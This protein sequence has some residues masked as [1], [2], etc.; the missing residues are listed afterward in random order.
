MVSLSCGNSSFHPALALA[1]DPS[2][3]SISSLTYPNMRPRHALTQMP[4]KYN[5]TFCFFLTCDFVHKKF[6][7][8]PFLAG[9]HFQSPALPT[10]SP[11]F[12]LDHK[13]KI[14]QPLVIRTP[15]H[16]SLLRFSPSFLFCC[17]VVFM[18]LCPCKFSFYFL[19]FPRFSLPP[20]LF[21]G[22][23]TEQNGVL[24]SRCPCAQTPASTPPGPP[25]IDG[26]YQ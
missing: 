7:S 9:L 8:T 20:Q 23:R 19:C 17:C 25:P 3:P 21:A 16:H 1:N 2:P 14:R 10:T 4:R 24:H 22:R 6:A 5:V 26:K 11:F 13:I 18:S 15:S 12:L